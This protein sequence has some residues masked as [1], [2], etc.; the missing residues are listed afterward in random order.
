MKENNFIDSNILIYAHTLQDQ[1]KM[2]IA[3]R[4]LSSEQTVIANTQV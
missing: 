2:K 1:N 3:Q 4:I